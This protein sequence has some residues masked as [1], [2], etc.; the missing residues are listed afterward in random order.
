MTLDVRTPIDVFKDTI[1]GFAARFP[2]C[3]VWRRSGQRLIEEGTESEEFFLI[4]RG[5]LS[6]L[7]RNPDNNVE[8][9][10]AVRIDGDIIGEGAILPTRSRRSASVLI[11]SDSALL[12]RLSRQDLWGLMRSDTVLKDAIMALST[13]ALARRAE[14]AQIL[15]S[16]GQPYRAQPSF[17]RGSFRMEP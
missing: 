4:Q 1:A 8:R 14:T 10:I 7:A 12:V 5:E 17:Y 16:D 6:V 13:L 3:V 9:E 15:G 2:Q 11:A